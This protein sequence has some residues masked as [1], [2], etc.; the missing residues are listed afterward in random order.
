MINNRTGQANEFLQRGGLAKISCSTA[1]ATLDLTVL[2][3]IPVENPF[4]GE[5]KTTQNL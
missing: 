2:L 3:M 1:P 4:P 5:K